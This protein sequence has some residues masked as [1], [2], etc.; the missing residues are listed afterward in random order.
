MDSSGAPV[1]G[2]EA[3][4]VSL[5]RVSRTDSL[6]RFTFASLPSGGLD[7]GVRRLGYRSQSRHVKITAA[8]CDSLA[9]VLV[10]QPV[11]LAEMDALG[12]TRHPLFQGFDQRHERGNGTFV[13]REQID[14]QNT[15][16][17]SDLFRT[18]PQ[19]RLV[20]AGA[21]VGVRFPSN[22]AFRGRGS[23]LCTPMLWLDGQQ[24]PGME[25]DDVRATDIE[26]IELYRGAARTPPQFA[27]PG[28]AQC[29]A[30]VVWTRRGRRLT[31]RDGG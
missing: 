31:Q 5:G 20:R 2:V 18:I 24:M 9:F 29:G 3:S 23:T 12:T 14:A 6:G 16:T 8:P 26:A 1:A 17:A 21:G 28:L 19:V 25:I 30:I 27:A 22:Q 11:P 13:T 7:I 4:I 15:V 10:T